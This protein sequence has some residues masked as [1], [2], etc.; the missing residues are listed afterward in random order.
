[1][2]LFLSD[3]DGEVATV[4]DVVGGVPSRLS[5][6]SGGESESLTTRNIF[7]GMWR[8]RSR[9][10]EAARVA[11]LLQ[12]RLNALIAERVAATARTVNGRR[13]SPVSVSDSRATSGAA[14]SGSMPRFGR[15]GSSRG[16]HAATGVTAP[17]HTAGTSPGGSTPALP[18]ASQRNAVSRLIASAETHPEVVAMAMRSGAV[19]GVPAAG[20]ESKTLESESTGRPQAA[21]AGP[22]STGA[23]DTVHPPSQ[24]AG[25]DSEQQLRSQIQRDMLKRAESRLAASMASKK[26]IMDRIAARQGQRHLRGSSPAAA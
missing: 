14:A 7:G 4:G 15:G 1:M 22:V 5:A 17:S 10:S 26:E 21:Q 12:D 25:D 20:S 16:Q 19:V 24:A 2:K 18:L 9:D 11:A 3:G 13:P 6:E 23:A 8:F